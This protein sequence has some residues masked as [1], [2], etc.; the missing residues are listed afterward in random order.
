MLVVIGC[1]G[2]NYDNYQVVADYMDALHRE[3]GVDV[4]INGYAKGA[5]KLFSRWAKDNKITSIY[6]MPADWNKHGKSAGYKRN[7]AMLQQAVYQADENRNDIRV[8]ATPGG[9]GTEMM[10]KIAKQE[11]IVV[12]R[13]GEE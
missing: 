6:D 5:D 10:I 1:G 8:I 11:D 3:I 2:R 12:Y 9:K 13:I 7:C 4:L